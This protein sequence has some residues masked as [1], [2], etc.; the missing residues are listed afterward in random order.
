MAAGDPGMLTNGAVSVRLEPLAQSRI[1]LSISVGKEPGRCAE[2]C[3]D[4]TFSNGDFRADACAIVVIGFGGQSRIPADEECVAHAVIRDG[5]AGALHVPERC[6]I[7]VRRRAVVDRPR[8]HEHRERPGSL[9]EARKG[10]AIHA[11]VSVVEGYGDGA[12]GER[13]PP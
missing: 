1:E 4:A 3:V 10:F 7:G 11:D 6:P 9:R 13:V 5:G 12:R 8:I 2:L